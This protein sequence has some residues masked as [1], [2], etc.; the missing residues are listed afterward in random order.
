MV[1]DQEWEKKVWDESCQERT[2]ADE[3]GEDIVVER[4]KPKRVE[5]ERG[6]QKESQAG[7]L[8]WSGMG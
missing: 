1:V 3:E 6:K 8:R 2:V 5:R 7:D 4:W